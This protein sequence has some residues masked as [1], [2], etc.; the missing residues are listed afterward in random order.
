[1]LRLSSAIYHE[2]PAGIFKRIASRGKV[3]AQYTSICLLAFLGGG[4]FWGSIAPL[5]LLLFG[6]FLL[7]LS[8]FFLSSIYREATA[9]IIKIIMLRRASP[10]ASYHQ[11]DAGLLGAEFVV[12]L[13]LFF[14]SSSFSSLSC[15]L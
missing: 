4:G 12:F 9:S 3:P 1:M 14:S 13:L 6:L 11:A 2:A 7:L 15:S 5:F 10:Y 8:F